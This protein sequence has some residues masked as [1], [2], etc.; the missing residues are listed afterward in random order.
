ME[1]HASHGNQCTN[2]PFPLKISFI[3]NSPYCLPNYSLKV[4][5]ENSA[6]NQLSNDPI[7]DIS[8]GEILL[9]THECLRLTVDIMRSETKSYHMNKLFISDKF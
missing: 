5:L 4:S 1:L 3:S 2:N 6:L 8:W 9:A 7:V